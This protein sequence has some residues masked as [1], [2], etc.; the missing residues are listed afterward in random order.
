MCVF[1]SFP[2]LIAVAIFGVLPVLP[3]QRPHACFFLTTVMLLCWSIQSLALASKFLSG[4]Y[5]GETESIM[6]APYCCF[7][8]TGLSCLTG[9]SNGQYSASQVNSIFE[10]FQQLLFVGM[11]RTSKRD[12]ECTV[13]RSCHN[14]IAR[15][16]Q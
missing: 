8:L 4:R 12:T 16:G 2:D 11:E 15:D 3:K 13:L 7:L 14:T 10:G 5:T 1:R 9:K 6:R